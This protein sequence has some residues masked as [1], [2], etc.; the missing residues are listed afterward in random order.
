LRSVAVIH[1]GGIGDFLQVLPV[2]AAIRHKWPEA[3][4]TIVG[5]RERAE[6]A[7]LG[8][9]AEGVVEFETCGCHHLFVD[10][11]R[12][13]SVCE[14]LRDADLIVSFLPQATFSENLERL[15]SARVIRARSFPAPG[16]CDVPAAQFVYDQVAAQL[17]L[18]AARAVPCINLAESPHRGNETAVI[19]PGSG[20]RRKN[21]PLDR[22]RRLA[23]RLAADGMPV[24]WIV[25]PAETESP[26]FAD[27]VRDANCQASPRLADLAVMLSAV[28]LY[29]GNDSGITHLAAAVGAPT[30]VLFGPS[31]AVVWA[32][33]G[34]NVRT[35]ISPT[36]RMDDI[37]LAEV[38]A[39][40]TAMLR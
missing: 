35:I 31:E 8:G 10:N 21:W 23:D 9:L 5:H 17:D 29:V 11:A 20:S 30:V 14:A 25:G 38:S 36:G 33:R 24:T 1:T 28:R 40:V 18:P 2:L 22:F 7:R 15:R 34:A 6:L 27:L 19:H 26:M 13:D 4:V 39:A 32:P 16:E 37:D 3:K 12:C